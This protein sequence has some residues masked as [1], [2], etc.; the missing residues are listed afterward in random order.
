M[1][2]FGLRKRAKQEFGSPGSRLVRN[3]SLPLPVSESIVSSVYHAPSNLEKD[4]N[5]EATGRQQLWT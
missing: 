1:F 3:V 2:D 5:F 4:E